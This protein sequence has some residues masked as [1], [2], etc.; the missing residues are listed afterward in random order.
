MKIR[1]SPSRSFP[2]QFTLEEWLALP[3]LGRRDMIRR[4]ACGLLDCARLCANRMCRRY[5]ACCADDSAA[6]ELRLRRLP[7]PRLAALLRELGRREGLAN[8]PAAESDT[9]KMTPKNALWTAA[10]YEPWNAPAAPPWRSLPGG[11][12]EGG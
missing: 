2:G 9:L 7:R 8:L 3:L 11:R 6:C 12:G 5:S 1:H 4:D 10:L